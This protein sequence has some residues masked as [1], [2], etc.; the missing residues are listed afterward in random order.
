M[1]FG[2]STGKN[3]SKCLEIVEISNYYPAN[4]VSFGKCVIRVQKYV[5]SSG[6]CVIR[7]QK[8]VIS[9]RKFVI[10]A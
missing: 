7:V 1:E 4:V 5:I 9:S 10:S 2:Q 6:K 3:E 8:Y